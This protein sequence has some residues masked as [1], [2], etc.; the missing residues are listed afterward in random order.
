MH[1]AHPRF[2]LHDGVTVQTADVL[3][4]VISPIRFPERALSASLL[5]LQLT[6]LVVGLLF[7]KASSRSEM[8]RHSSVSPPARNPAR[9][10]EPEGLPRRRF[11]LVSARRLSG[12]WLFRCV[13]GTRVLVI[14]LIPR[15][16]ASRSRSLGMS[17]T[18]NR[19]FVKPTSS[20]NIRS[21]PN[22]VRRVRD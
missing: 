21:L 20:A 3:Q 2:E 14:V 10:R 5:A 16:H 12:R 18:L 1:F 9:D 8:R 13:F 22:P 17:P 15:R 6:A 7:A 4:R 11:Y 19:R